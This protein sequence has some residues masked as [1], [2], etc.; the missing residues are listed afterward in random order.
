MVMHMEVQLS[1]C[2]HPLSHLNDLLSLLIATKSL[3]MA[4]NKHKDVTVLFIKQND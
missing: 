3:K 2:L 1:A 4:I